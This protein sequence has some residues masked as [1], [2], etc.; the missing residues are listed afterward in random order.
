[1]LT[2]VPAFLH[3]VCKIH[4]QCLHAYYSAY[5]NHFWRHLGIYKNNKIT[6][7]ILKYYILIWPDMHWLLFFV[8]FILILNQI[9]KFNSDWKA[10]PVSLIYT[11]LHR[12]VIWLLWVWKLD[13]TVLLTTL[14]SELSWSFIL[15]CCQTLNTDSFKMSSTSASI[16]DL[17]RFNTVTSQLLLNFDIK[18]KYLTSVRVN[19]Y[20]CFL[21]LL[22]NI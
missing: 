7:Y 10:L 15:C 3:I 1:M 2:L 22:E 12:G 17:A 5:R 18:D 19:T 21:F 6:N 16:D 20:S 8:K 9:N 4:S 14:F 11:M 13:S